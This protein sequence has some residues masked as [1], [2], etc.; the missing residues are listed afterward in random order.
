MDQ[1]PSARYLTSWAGVCP[2]SNESA[3]KKKKSGKKRGE[4]ASGF[5]VCCVR[6]LGPPSHCKKSYFH[7]HC[8]PTSLASAARN[9]PALSRSH[10]ASLVSLTSC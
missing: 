3:G 9:A 10:T 8:Q 4:V 1:F 6:A 5:G 2:G 7:A